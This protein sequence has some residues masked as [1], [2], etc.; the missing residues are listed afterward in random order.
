ML[1][2]ESSNISMNDTYSMTP[3][4]SPREPANTRRFCSCAKKTPAAPI[5]VD[6]DAAS[7]KMKASETLSLVESP[8]IENMTTDVN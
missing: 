1:T 3:A 6:K 4:E 8:L 7:V 2:F 5:D